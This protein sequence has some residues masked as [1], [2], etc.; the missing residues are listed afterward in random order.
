M[1]V[2][3][4]GWFRMGTAEKGYARSFREEPKHRV[5]ITKPFAAG[6]FEVTFAEWRACVANGG[7]KNYRSN[8]HGWGRGRRPVINVSWDDAKSYISWL[9]R[10]TGQNYRLLTESEWEYVARAGSTTRY[11]WGPEVDRNKANCDGCGSRWDS[12]QTAPVGRFKANGFGLHDLLGNVSEWVEDCWN[13]T[14]RGAP[15]DGS[16]WNSG[17]CG[18]RVLR[19]GSWLDSYVDV[20]SAYRISNRFK[21]R[22]GTNGFRIAKT[23]Y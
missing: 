19:G 13:K 12:R 17:K 8:D 16:A 14:Y 4:A 21:T 3:P 9:S 23:L 7:C 5:T 1:V 20:R 11:S 18:R 6:K 22:F 2:I 15:S 10:K